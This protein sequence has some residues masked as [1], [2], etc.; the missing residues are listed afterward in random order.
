MIDIMMIRT[1][2]VEIYMIDIWL[3]THISSR[4]SSA[5]LVEIC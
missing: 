2:L 3:M 5:R 1:H 4:L